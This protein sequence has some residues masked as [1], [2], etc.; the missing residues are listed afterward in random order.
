MTEITADTILTTC[1]SLTREQA[2]EVA[3]ALEEQR[4]I[5]QKIAGINLCIKEENEYRNK[6]I[7]E[8]ESERKKIQLRCKH[9][10][11]EFHSDPSGGSD[12]SRE[13][14]ICGK[15]MKR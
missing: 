11:I 7:K 2:I 5:R 15:D 8:L 13:C 1:S 4:S 14:L 6:S 12:S 10:S 9:T 3:D